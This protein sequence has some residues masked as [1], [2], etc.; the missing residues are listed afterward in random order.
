MSEKTCP[1]HPQTP[2]L[3]TDKDEEKEYGFCEECLKW[4]DTKTG[5][6]MK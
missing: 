3:M 4:Y 2:F 6:P 1:I 5:E